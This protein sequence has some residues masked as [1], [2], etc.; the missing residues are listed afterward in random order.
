MLAASWIACGFVLRRRPVPP[1][2]G[3]RL[4]MGAVAFAVLIGLELLVGIIG[5]GRPVA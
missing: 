1:Q 5:F 2:M 3:P 4:V